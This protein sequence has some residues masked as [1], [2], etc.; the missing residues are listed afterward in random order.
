MKTPDSIDAFTSEWIL[1]AMKN[2]FEDNDK[3]VVESFQARKNDV[4]G[5]LST[6]FIVDVECSLNGE[7]HSKSLFVKVP[8]KDEPQFESVNRRELVMFTD[9]LPRLQTFLDE[10]CEGFFRLPMPKAIHCHY[11]GRGEK[12][13]F[14]LENLLEEGYYN[15]SG[16]KCLNVE[17]MNAVLDSLCYLHG[18]GLAFKRS[19]GD[20]SVQD[21]HKS[22]PNLDVQLQLDDLIRES[23][24]REHFRKHFRPFL[25]YLE[26]AEPGLQRHTSYMSKMHK[27]ILAVIERLEHCGYENFI[28][29]AH[30][31][32]K[33]NNF[34]FRKIEIDLEELEC[35]GI[36]PILIDWQGGFL[37]SAANDLMWAL[38]PFLEF[39]KALF[40]KAVEYYHD[41]L[42]NVLESFNCSL[43][44]VGLPNSLPEFNSLLKK[45]LVLEFLI[46]T[47][48][49]P[50][51]SI[52]NH[53]KL[54]KWHK[55]TQKNKRRRFKKEVLK[56]QQTEILSSPR[57]T[58]FCHL[59]FRIATAL[60]AFQELG[61]IYF[62]TM[63]EN[64]F[65]VDK[66]DDYDSDLEDDTDLISRVL[67]APTRTLIRA[68]VG[69]ALVAVAVIAGVAYFA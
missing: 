31:D 38:F 1:F 61:S 12:D 39:N 41:Q 67:N 46:V 33:P 36:D 64:M 58:G 51:M 3:V 19:S 2:L 44:D 40:P 49:K 47:V 9:V 25:H 15:F 65:E 16:E 37:G 6:T 62:E 5:I 63:K 34:M 59:Y 45:C 20:G 29:L 54:L 60:G 7:S 66:L 14:V 27:H 28:T 55:E 32:A 69:F 68:S 18:T 10:H 56:P 30:G 42:K 57:F 48:I 53:E 22:F 23:P 43:E 26:E 50:I 35:E 17:H 8:L 4:Q 13:V 11:D 21:M 52:E 24:M